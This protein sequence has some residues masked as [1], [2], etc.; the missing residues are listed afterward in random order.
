MFIFRPGSPT[1]FTPPLGSPPLR[2]PGSW[3]LHARET[4][5]LGRKRGG[6]ARSGTLCPRARSLVSAGLRPRL[7]RARGWR[8][9]LAQTWAQPCPCGKA[10]TT[11][12]RVGGVDPLQVVGGCPRG[13][14]HV[15]RGTGSRW[16]LGQGVRIGEN[17]GGPRWAARV[18]GK[19]PPMN[20]YVYSVCITRGQ[21]G[22][23]GQ[24]GV[25]ERLE[26]VS[27]ERRT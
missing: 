10:G 27:G 7:G 3:A 25:R 12:G 14:W 1:L 21:W 5:G 15:A 13:Q 6:G 4:N 11:G 18:G 8:L 17:T 20:L 2:T 26:E 23:E 22:A 19:R 16:P 9:G 24:G